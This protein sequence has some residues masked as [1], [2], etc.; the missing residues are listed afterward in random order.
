MATGDEKGDLCLGLNRGAITL[1]AQE[2]G[3]AN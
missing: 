1:E 3:I 2:Q